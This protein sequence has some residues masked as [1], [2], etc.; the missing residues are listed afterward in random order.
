MLRSFL[1]AA[2]CAIALSA[3][4]AGPTL[5]QV[6]TFIDEEG[7]EMVLDTERYR[8]S[9]YLLF[10]PVPLGDG[11]MSAPRLLADTPQARAINAELVRLGQVRIAGK[12]Q[13]INGDCEIDRSYFTT[14]YGPDYVA[15][16]IFT[17]GY[18]E[19]SDEEAEEWHRVTFDMSTGQPVDLAA[20][21]P[22]LRLQ[23][24]DGSTSLY[25]G[26]YTSPLLDRLYVER[27][28]QEADPENECESVWT[29]EAMAGST[30]ALILS[31]E[32]GGLSFMPELPQ[33]MAAC[34]DPVTLSADELAAYGASDRLVRALRIAH[35]GGHWA[36]QFKDEED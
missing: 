25:D 1:R 6:Q 35:E 3:C 34:G 11:P 15:F 7:D 29:A 14:L 20:A 12:V 5:A 2:V 10:A 31:A 9:Y 26:R 21:L 17:G 28:T 18:C 22:A 33:V 27:I 4:A 24:S 13:D 32:E 36:P 30:Y 19:D 23:A 16:D 8:S